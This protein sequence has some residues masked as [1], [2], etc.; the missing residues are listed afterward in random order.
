MAYVSIRQA[1]QAYTDNPRVAEITVE[2]K[3]YEA[4][5]QILFDIAKHPNAKVRGGMSKATR[6]QKMILD[7]R[8]G[9]RRPGTNPVVMKKESVEFH[10][11]TTAEIKK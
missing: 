8:V 2:T 5:P 7:R 3:V 10:D 4:I 1:L 6:A 11:L 9:T